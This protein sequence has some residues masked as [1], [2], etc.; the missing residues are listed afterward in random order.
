MKVWSSRLGRI[1]VGF[2]I[3]GPLLL[4]GA[5]A[6]SPSDPRFT[7]LEAPPWLAQPPAGPGKSKGVVYF[8]RGG[9]RFGP[10]DEFSAAPYFL[11]T[12]SEHGWDVIQAKYPRAYVARHADE[13]LMRRLI[14]E[15]VAFVVR[16]IQQLDAEG[17]RRI[18]LIAHGT[19]TH[20]AMRASA[21]GLRRADVMV[22]HQPALWG[23]RTLS[24]SGRSNPNYE[25]NAHSF[26]NFV[27]DVRIPTMLIAAS[28]PL[29]LTHP[30]IPDIAR[31]HFAEHGVPNAVIDRPPGFV[32]HHAGW[33]PIFDFVFGECIRAFIE[34]AK[35]AACWRTQFSN[36]D[37]RTIFN[38]KQIADAKSRTISTPQPLLGKQYVVYLRGKPFVHLDHV[39]AAQRINVQFDENFRE[40]YAFRNGRL[41]VGK[42]CSVLVKWSDRELLEFVAATG[43]L[44]AWWIRR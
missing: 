30:K 28:D 2:L 31:R 41:C 42:A 24:K 4:S 1:L 13:G 27:A 33:L 39:S 23:P 8:L 38:L 15:A 35:M 3:C 43:A 40:S 36:E 14:P 7:L 11:K 22:L 9:N 25:K 44:K 16:R 6:Q 34:E 20:V 5:S 26:Q 17:Y 29:G 37:F 21:K 12:L 19:A 18:V 32:G 10:L